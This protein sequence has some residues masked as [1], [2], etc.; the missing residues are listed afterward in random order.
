MKKI[1]VFYGQKGVGKDTCCDAYRNVAFFN[2]QLI[3]HV[4]Y[5]KELKDVVWN[6]FGKLIGKQEYIYGTIN[7]KETP[8]TT[9][10][11]S[12][13]ISK[14]FGYKETYWTGR[15]LLQWFGTDMC[16]SV[17]SMI[18][19]DKAENKIKEADS[20]TIVITDCRFKNEYDSLLKMKDEFKVIFV[21][22]ERKTDLN[23]FGSHV[24]E[25][26]ID[27]FIYDDLLL[28]DGTIADMEAKIKKLFNKYK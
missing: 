14:Q 21:K 19:V 12:P 4:S 18:W 23:T 6:L 17:Y 13:E 24:S 10:E 7:E 15:R 25:A 28:N 8:I 22:V 2:N 9:W 27:H 11:I 20:D 3:S 1:I 5:A 16:R 26:G